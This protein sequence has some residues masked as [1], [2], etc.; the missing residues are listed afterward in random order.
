MF[1]NL[2]KKNYYFLST[3]LIVFS[4]LFIVYVE[5]ASV[6]L[7]L[8]F[9][10]CLLSKDCNIKMLIKNLKI[11]TLFSFIFIAITLPLYEFTF[12][13]LT[14]QINEGFLNKNNWWAYFGGFIIGRENPI[15]SDLFVSRIQSLI[16][17]KLSLYD[18]LTL[19][20]SELINHNYKHYFLN[21]I[22]SFFGLYY[23]TD[24]KFLLNIES[25]NI[26]YLIFLNLLILFYLA[27]NFIIVM[28]INSNITLLIKSY[29]LTLVLFSL[30]LI[31]LNQYWSVIKLYFY[32]APILWF[33]LVFN[34]KIINKDMSELRVNRYVILL[35]I[36]FPF[37]KLSAFNNGITRHDSFPSILNKESK[38]EILWLF[39]DDHFKNCKSINLNIYENDKINRFKN[40]YLSL[41]LIFNDYKF[42]N[43]YSLKKIHDT[44]KKIVDMKENNCVINNDYFENLK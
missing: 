4:S 18:L 24:V 44:K 28:R 10:Y 32:L 14:T 12:K 22:P 39:K 26:I 29:F 13:F 2:N 21:I 3:F 38:K 7:L 31:F 40:L 16:N 1:D 11:I 8:F 35:L 42:T 30:V 23:L 17:S 37:Y 41:N 15:T 33:F 6:F 36:I 25:I 19:I 20:N 9:I 43:K 27:N 5:L 34:F